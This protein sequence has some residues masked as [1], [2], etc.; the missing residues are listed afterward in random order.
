MKSSK[1]PCDSGSGLTHKLRLVK[2]SA[3]IA[4]NLFT[5]SFKTEFPIGVLLYSS[6]RSGVGLESSVGIATRYGMDG[7]GIESRWRRDFPTLSDRPRG[8]PS[9]LYNA[10]RVFPGVTAL[11]N[12]PHL[13]P[14]LKKE[15]ISTIPLGLRG[16]F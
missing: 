9:L 1:Q 16:L 2:C 6:N 3:T 13:E 10:Y 14:R 5:S 15:Y 11:T 4:P 12:H 7:L 8:P